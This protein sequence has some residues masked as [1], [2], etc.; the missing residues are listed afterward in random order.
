MQ[1]IHGQ[2][3]SN[4]IHLVGG[5]PGIP[6][7]G[8]PMTFDLDGVVTWGNNHDDLASE[9]T[10]EFSLLVSHTDS[11]VSFKSDTIPDA[12]K[13]DQTV[14]YGLDTTPDGSTTNVVVTSNLTDPSIGN[15]CLGTNSAIGANLRSVA[16]QFI[17]FARNDVKCV[18]SKNGTASNTN[19]S[20]S[21][22]S[23]VIGSLTYN[24][25]DTKNSELLAV[26]DQDPN[27]GFTYSVTLQ[28]GEVLTVQINSDRSFHSTQLIRPD[29][30]ILN[31]QE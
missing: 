27:P 14:V 23:I 5:N 20:F 24:S 30:S 2:Y 4:C 13:P 19:V 28:T 25:T 15:G 26:M 3:A 21:S 17:S 6:N 16:N 10:N 12:R 9:L 29:G 7:S 11:M 8:V 18:D 31:C 1:V 22:S